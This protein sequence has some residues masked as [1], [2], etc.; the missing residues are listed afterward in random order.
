MKAKKVLVIVMALCLLAAACACAAEQKPAGQTTAEQP[1]AEQTTAGQMPAAAAGSGTTQ[2]SVSGCY[3]G[4]KDF[5]EL[6][7]QSTMIAR[8]AVKET[9]HMSDF[10]ETARLEVKQTYEGEPLDEIILYQLDDEYKLK[11]GV[12]YVLFLLSMP[13][14]PDQN[15]Y[16]TVGG[17]QGIFPIEKDG[18]NTQHFPAGQDAVLAWYAEQDPA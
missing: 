1:S 11:E 5:D 18:L 2:T 17:P 13:D 15:V 14:A 16:C 6:H 9:W 7:A 12:D 3:I 10:T 8:C 4:V